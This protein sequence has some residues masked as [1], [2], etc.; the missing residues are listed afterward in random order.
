MIHIGDISSISK[1]EWQLYLFVFYS[2]TLLLPILVQINLS[3]V[4]T[5]YI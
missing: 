3:Q 4:T 1:A 2:Y 5:N